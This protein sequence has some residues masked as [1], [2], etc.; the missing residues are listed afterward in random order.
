MTFSSLEHTHTSGLR[1]PHWKPLDGIASQTR[2]DVGSNVAGENMEPPK[3][4]LL[5][6]GQM[7]C[8]CNLYQDV[9]V[10]DGNYDKRGFRVATSSSSSGSSPYTLSMTA[11]PPGSRKVQRANTSEVPQRP[12]RSHPKSQKAGSRISTGSVEKWSPSTSPH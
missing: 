1:I 6:A 5:E 7:D 11:G 8:P 3:C 12:D 9:F 4:P 10:S 2:K